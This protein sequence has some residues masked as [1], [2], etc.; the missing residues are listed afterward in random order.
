MYLDNTNTSSSSKLKYIQSNHKE[1]DYFFLK[2]MFEK[3][4]TQDG[5]SNIH[6]ELLDVTA[7]LLIKTHN[8]KT[9]LPTIVDMIFFRN[10]EGLFTHDL[11]WAFFQAKDPY[12]LMLIGNY[13]ESDDVNDVKLA[14]K[15]LDFVPSIDFN[16]GEG[17]KQHKSLFYWLKENYHFLQFTGESFQ[18]VSNPIPYIVAIDSKYLCKEVSLYTGE[19]ILPLTKKQTNLLGHFNNL[20]E[21][22]K[23]LLS[24]FSHRIHCKNVNSWSSWIK[25]SITKQISTAKAR[26]KH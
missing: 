7:T 19:P 14:C 9:I 16:K 23:L 18:R 15:L 2:D 20:D 22:K 10:R 17:S 11:I 5:L 21:N 3:S 24:K 6:D 1:I 26:S 12:S 4:M 13:L 8:D 25:Q